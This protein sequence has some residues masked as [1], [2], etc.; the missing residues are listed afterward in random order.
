MWISILQDLSPRGLHD[1]KRLIGRRCYSL[2]KFR[3]VEELDRST[4][5]RSEFEELEQVRIL[6]RGA[7]NESDSRYLKGKFE[8]IRNQSYTV[9]LWNKQNR[10]LRIDDG[11]IL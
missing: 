6:F 4:N 9:H 2:E 3:Q 11:R 7:K 1:V 5:N 10:V 8:Q